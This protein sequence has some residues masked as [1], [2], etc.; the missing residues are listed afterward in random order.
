MKSAKNRFIAI[1][2]AFLLLIVLSFQLSIR[3]AFA[4]KQLYVKYLDQEK[5][6]ESVQER[7]F[8]LNRQNALLAANLGGED[9]IDQGFEEALLQEVGSFAAD[10]NLQLIEFSEKMTARDQSFQVETIRL[11]L[12]GSFENHIRL[13]N[14]LEE[15]FRMGTVVSVDYELRRDLGSR[16]QEL[17]QTIFVQNLFEDES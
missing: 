12:K 13:L 15:E 11:S 3:K 1:L 4:E 14:Y 16:K 17:F 7:M 6:L 8:D 9:L 2:V 5:L 10:H